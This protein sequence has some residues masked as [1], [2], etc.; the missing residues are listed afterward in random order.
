M[1]VCDA[2]KKLI[3]F[4]NIWPICITV[5]R[6]DLDNWTHQSIAGEIRNPNKVNR[7]SMKI[8][9]PNREFGLEELAPSKSLSNKRLD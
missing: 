1:F 6:L 7:L 2:G 5:W 3:S 9:L 8:R 4:D